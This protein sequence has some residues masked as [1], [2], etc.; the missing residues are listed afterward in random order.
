MVWTI[1]V[2][3]PPYTATG[4]SVTISQF[5]ELVNDVI[6]LE[7]EEWG[8]EDYAVEVEGFECLHFAELL[9]V[10]KEDDEVW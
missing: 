9:Q 2:P 8:L 10:L 7:A 4:T 5:L 3:R 1:G 6:P